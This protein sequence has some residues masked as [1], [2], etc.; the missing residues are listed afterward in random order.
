MCVKKDVGESEA[1]PVAHHLSLRSFAAIE[2]K[3]LAFASDCDRR[4]VA[5]DCRARCGGA[6]EANG[7]RHGLNISEPNSL[8]EQHLPLLPADEAS[9]VRV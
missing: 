1:G 7:E 9:T 3:R 2:K 8:Q 4:N 5:L 6:E